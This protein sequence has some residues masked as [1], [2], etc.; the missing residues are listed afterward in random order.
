MDIERRSLSGLVTLRAEGEPTV[1]GYAAMY[2]AETVIAGLWRE[3]IAPGAFA[4][5]LDGSDDVRALFNHDPNFLLGRTKSGTLRLSEDK[6]GLRYDVD[7][8]DT[9]QA[10]DVRELIRRGDVTGSSFGF[11]I[12]E[13]EWDDTPL[14]RGLLP[15]LTIR[16]VELFDV[17]P[18]TFPAYPQTSVSARAK[19]EASQA[20]LKGFLARQD[21]MARRDLMRARIAIARA[22]AWA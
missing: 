12:E 19:G 18:V 2:N 14:K 21:E 4:T 9:Q 20:A 5:A 1:R 3:Q 10:R 15:L 7:L 17:S 6:Q 13:D 8:P 16:K 11:R 22:K